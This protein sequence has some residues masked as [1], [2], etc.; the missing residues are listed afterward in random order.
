MV[1]Y[2]SVTRHRAILAIG[3]WAAFGSPATVAGGPPGH[4]GHHHGAAASEPATEVGQVPP[5]ADVR[6]MLFDAVRPGEGGQIVWQ[7]FWKLCWAPV[8]GAEAYELRRMTSEGSPRRPQ[9]VDDTCWQVEVAAG[10]NPPEAGLYRRDLMVQMQAAQ[11]S[12]R[13][14][15]AFPDGRVSAWSAEF[16]VGDTKPAVR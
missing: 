7:T 8:Q 10:E 11:S 5:P 2:Q 14:R 13:V 6:A 1:Q 15:A 12:L 9:R 4:H 16:A 3:L